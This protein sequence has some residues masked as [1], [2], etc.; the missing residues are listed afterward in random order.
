MLSDV[1][2][3]EAALLESIWSE[4]DDPN[5]AIPLE[6]SSKATN[7]PFL[8]QSLNSNDNV[9]TEFELRKHIFP[10]LLLAIYCCINE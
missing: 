1:N 2:N 4:H 10:A 6:E 5:R 3:A 7:D 9:P 8:D